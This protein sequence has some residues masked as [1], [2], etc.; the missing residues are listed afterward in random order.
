MSKID[1]DGNKLGFH[2]LSDSRGGLSSEL[3]LSERDSVWLCRPDELSGG[4]DGLF[5]SCENSLVCL[6]RSD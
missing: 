3:E 1:E 5:V 4:L 2:G 6:V